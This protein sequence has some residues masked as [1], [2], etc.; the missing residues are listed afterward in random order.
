MS[1]RRVDS[2]TSGPLIST[3]S[4][5]PRPVPTSSAVGVA[6]PRAHGQAMIST[7][8]AVANAY[9]AS[10]PVPSQKPSVATARPITI[11]TN[12]AETRSARRC[13]SAFPLC[14]SVTSRPIWASAVSA[15]TFVARTTSR[16]P[17][18]TVAPITSSPGPTS[19]GDA[20]AGDDRRVDGRSALDDDAVRRDLLAGAHHEQVARAKLLDGSAAFGAVGAE[21]GDVLRAEL[22]QAAQGRAR[23]ALR[24][25]LEE[26]PCQD[27]SGHDGGHL[28]VELTAAG[29]GAELEREG[30][31]HVQL[32]RRRG[33]TAPPR[34]NPR[35][36][37]CRA[38]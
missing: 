33:R 26:P 6:R 7:A 17:T 30:H 37:A 9:A 11:G 32:D 1:V 2:S 36:R 10:A 23:P 5:A 31:A 18:L 28:E 20:L 19:D 8:T 22:E 34:T 4:C 27:E 25:G 38:R 13:T 29:A 16:P 21:D 24:A 14:A 12:T 15:P 35:R 3:P